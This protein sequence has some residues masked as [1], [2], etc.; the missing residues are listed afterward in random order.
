MLALSN[1]FRR[2]RSK[3]LRIIW[4]PWRHYHIGKFWH[5]C[6]RRLRL[7]FH[8][9]VYDHPMDSWW[10]AIAQNKFI[11]LWYCL[12]AFKLKPLISPHSKCH[13]LTSLNQ[14]HYRWTI[15][16]YIY[17]YICFRF[18]FDG[19]NRMTSSGVGNYSSVDVLFFICLY[20]WH[21]NLIYH[22][23]ITIHQVLGSLCLA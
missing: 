17:I 6:N 15:C 8:V 14:I 20:G 4:L 22:V 9:S 1:T 16:I 13:N 10:F 19:S 3:Y 12:G 21:A 5:V 11:L 23:D 2:T 18:R 7:K